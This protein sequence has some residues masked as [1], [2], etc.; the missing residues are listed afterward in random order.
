[1]GNC[2]SR[3]RQ[4]ILHPIHRV[5]N[6]ALQA[7]RAIKRWHWAV[8]ATTRILRLRKRWAKLGIYL[9]TPRIQSLIEGLERKKGLLI[10]VKSVLSPKIPFLKIRL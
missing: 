4:P 3:S 6:S 2:P 8:R 1:M 10:R 7:S 9:Q 5:K